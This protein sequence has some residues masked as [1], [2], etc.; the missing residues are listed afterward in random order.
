M[1]FQPDNV[2]RD[3]GYYLAEASQLTP[4]FQ[5]RGSR[6]LGIDGTWDEQQY[7]RLMGGLNP[8]DGSKLTC[9]L[10]ANRRLATDLT[11]N[12]D[13]GSSVLE[14]L[15][16][17]DRIAAVRDKAEAKAMRLVE[18]Q[19]RVQVRKQSELARSKASHPKGW[20][21][22]ERRSENLIWVAFRHPASREGDPH[23]HTHYCVMNLAF[24]K[25][26]R[27]W[28]GVELRHIDRK[29]INQVYHAE[30]AKGL[31]RL[32]YQ[33]TW[34]G[35]EISV[36]GV[37]PEVKKEFSTRDTRIKAKEK[38]YDDKAAAEGKQPMG[39]KARAKLSVYDRPEKAPDLPLEERRRVWMA[40]ITHTQYDG[41]RGLVARAKAGVKRA[42]WRQESRQAF[43][44]MRGVERE[45][46]APERSVERGRGR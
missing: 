16:G 11:F 43:D 15:A 38:A 35:K 33:A 41:L 9:R 22:P 46:V 44:R 24:D 14:Q 45:T 25:E 30:L 36:A 12:T 13:K 32:G 19:A 2:V 17:D 31:K 10:V 3:A 8:H 7:F 40:R 26:E 21:Y 37:S 18:K 23:S 29:E 4:E 39:A 1:G 42:R 28:K 6:L 27:V 20:K 34:D 5:G